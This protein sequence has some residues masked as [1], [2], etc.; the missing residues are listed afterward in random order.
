MSTEIPR[1]PSAAWTGRSA[2]HRRRV[3]WRLLTVFFGVLA[4]LAS[5][6]VLTVDAIRNDFDEVI[7]LGA[8]GIP[9]TGLNDEEGISFAG[10]YWKNTSVLPITILGVEPIPMPSDWQFSQMRLGTLA[11][12]E[13]PMRET[14]PFV[15]Q[16]LAPGEVA[17]VVIVY[18]AL[19]CDS[20]RLADGRVSGPIGFRMV[21][22]ILGVHR[23]HEYRSDGGGYGPLS[24]IGCSDRDLAI[25]GT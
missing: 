11:S 17:H 5:W 15:P 4:V 21:Y 25:G 2:V 10:Y 13:D 24:V 1:P 19:P 9:L 6:Y 22:S 12:G 16:H 8:D 18:E 23:T 7:R 3:P 14:K 20:P